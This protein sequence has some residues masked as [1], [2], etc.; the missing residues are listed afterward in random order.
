MASTPEGALLT[1]QHRWLQ[2]SNRARVLRLLGAAFAALDPHALDQTFPAYSSAATAVL[3]DGQVRAEDLAYAYLGSYAQAETG[4]GRIGP[5]IRRVLDPITLRG[6]LEL[7]GPTTARRYRATGMRVEQA[8]RQALGRTLATSGSIT[9]DAG[10]RV[11]A[12]EIERS[13]R[14]IGY[15][16]VTGPKPC[17]WC[18]LLTTR[19]AVYRRDTVNFR[20]H[21]NCG[22]FGEPVLRGTNGLAY[23]GTTDAQQRAAEL[24]S[25]TYAPGRDYSDRLRAYRLAYETAAS[26]PK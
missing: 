19:G 6:V 12:A 26:S 22:C 3:I 8:Y 9:L 5:L 1:K 2:L 21:R 15:Q 14:W 17:Y 23:P 10:R 4:D 18:V 13:G 11:V 7:T 24:W 16:R 20:A 25:A